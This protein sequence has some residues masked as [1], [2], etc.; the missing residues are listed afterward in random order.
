MHINTTCHMLFANWRVLRQTDQ[1]NWIENLKKLYKIYLLSLK[2]IM[3]SLTLGHRANSKVLLC[4]AKTSKFHGNSNPTMGWLSSLEAILCQSSA[5]K[6][7]YLCPNSQSRLIFTPLVFSYLYTI[8]L[9]IEQFGFLK[10]ILIVFY[11]FPTNPVSV[12]FESKSG[13]RF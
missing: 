6:T 12:L 10:G 7:I 4:L 8:T 9:Y 5:N 13:N 11:L 1:T 3:L 2:Y